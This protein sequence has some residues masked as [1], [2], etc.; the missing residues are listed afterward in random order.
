MS[1]QDLKNLIPPDGKAIIYIIRS[2][3]TNKMAKFR[4][5]WIFSFSSMNAL[6]RSNEYLRC[7]PIVLQSTV[8]VP[9]PS[10]RLM[11][12]VQTPKIRDA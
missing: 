9:F 3:A 4:F 6:S 12:L 8:S 10:Q 1:D 5:L 2:K 7:L 11:V